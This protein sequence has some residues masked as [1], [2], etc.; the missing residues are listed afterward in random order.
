MENE[1]NQFNNNELNYYKVEYENQKVESLP[2]FKKW[3]SNTSKYISEENNRRCKFKN[4]EQDKSILLIGYCNEC[5]SYTINSFESTFSFVSCKNCNHTFCIGCKRSALSG[6]D[7]SLCL[8]GYFKLLFIRYKYRLAGKLAT[9]DIVNVICTILCIL[10]TPCYFGFVSHFIGFQVHQNINGTYNDYALDYFELIGLYSI[11]RG[12]LMLPYIFL[13]LP[14]S[15]I[16]LIISVFN[17]KFFFKINSFYTSA[18]EPT[19]YR[20]EIDNN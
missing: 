17:H 20:L 12:M 11:F 19:N 10:F 9:S 13:F 3:Y 8:K 1:Y 18:I 16:L 2:D 4:D 6:A 15:F 7:E 14:F 5:K